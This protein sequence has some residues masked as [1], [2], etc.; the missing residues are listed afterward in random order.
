M[1][2]TKIVRAMTVSI[3]ALTATF[4]PAAVTPTVVAPYEIDNPQAGPV[5]INYFQFG[6]TNSNG[7]FGPLTGNRIVSSRVTINFRPGLVDNGNGQ[8]VPFNVNHLE[9]SMV[10]PVLLDD[11]NGSELFEVL[12]ADM[13][14]TSP[15]NYAHE[16]VTDA[17]NGEIRSGR[18][19]L[20]IEAFDAQG[21]PVPLAGE[22]FGGSGFYY[23]VAVPEPGF[24]V[25]LP[26]LAMLA[27]RRR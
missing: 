13:V 14:Q 23:T 26:A 22:F 9:V 4:A 15:G 11:P 27:V 8:M 19:S 6:Y 20:D 25:V 21:E 7:D 10:V 3:G 5:S 18:F 1:N 2:L 12:G 16:L 24:M 17:F